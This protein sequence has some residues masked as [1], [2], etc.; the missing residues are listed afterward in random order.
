MNVGCCGLLRTW[1]FDFALFKW[2][3]RSSLGFFFSIPLISWKRSQWQWCEITSCYSDWLKA[4]TFLGWTNENIIRKLSLKDKTYILWALP[5]PEFNT[6]RQLRNFENQ[7]HFIFWSVNFLKIRKCACRFRQG[8][9]ST[10]AVLYCLAWLRRGRF[11]ARCKANVPG[12]SGRVAPRTYVNKR[13]VSSGQIAGE[14]RG[15]P[16]RTIV[17]LGT[18]RLFRLPNQSFRALAPSSH[19]FFFLSFKFLAMLQ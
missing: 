9:Y 8:G 14:V 11:Y 18:F 1:I 4:F 10:A 16:D 12:N 17:F 5:T 19:S 2:S 15:L 3:R 13:A 6:F 7:F